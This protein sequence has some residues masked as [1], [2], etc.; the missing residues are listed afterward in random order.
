MRAKQQRLSCLPFGCADHA[1]GASLACG[2][3]Q[4]GLDPLSNGKKCRG[5]FVEL[6]GVLI[7]SA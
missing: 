4:Q 6:V 5:M 2:A 7:Q 3:V 1:A